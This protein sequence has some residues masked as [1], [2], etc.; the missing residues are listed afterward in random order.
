MLAVPEGKPNPPVDTVVSTESKA[1]DKLWSCLGGFGD[2]FVSSIFLSFLSVYL[3]NILFIQCGL[4]LATLPH[5]S[6][7]QRE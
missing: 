7:K 4:L 1:V 3:G 5:N 2:V 6:L